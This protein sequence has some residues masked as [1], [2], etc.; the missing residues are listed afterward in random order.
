MPQSTRKQSRD[1]HWVFRELGKLCPETWSLS[2]EAF[3][4]NS[5]QIRLLHRDEELPDGRVHEEYCPI[6]AVCYSCTGIIYS[7]H[8]WDRAGR[9][10]GLRY[11][12]TAFILGAADT[13]N[14]HTRR[15]L[16]ALRHLKFDTGEPVEDL[17]TN[18]V[19]L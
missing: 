17:L 4:E 18:L 11:Q 8:F 5:P 10:L 2:K 16:E 9:K 6:T 3:L 12:T 13:Q 7:L 19:A 14:K 1:Q 15:L